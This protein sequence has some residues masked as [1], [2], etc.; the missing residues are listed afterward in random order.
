MELI[1][2]SNTISRWVTTQVL[3]TE[4]RT[5]QSRL[6][7][8]FIRI[9]RKC[10]KMNNFN[11]AMDVVIGLGDNSVQRLKVVWERLTPKVLNYWKELEDLFSPRHNYK[12]YRRTLKKLKVPVLP[13]LG[14]SLPS[15]FLIGLPPSITFDN[16]KAFIC[17]M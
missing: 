17:E 10:V 12:R 9:A 8:K 11:S 13:Y 7:S 3:I 6:I 15:F 2:Q 4:G 14:E 1:D 5:A 16:L